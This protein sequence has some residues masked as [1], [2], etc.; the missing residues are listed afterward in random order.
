M[1]SFANSDR[2]KHV[3]MDKQIKD[4]LNSSDTRKNVSAHMGVTVQSVYKLGTNWVDVHKIYRENSIHITKLQMTLTDIG[5]L[6]VQ[7]LTV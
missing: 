5:S 4:S 2:N 1:N 6:V 3:F 7:A